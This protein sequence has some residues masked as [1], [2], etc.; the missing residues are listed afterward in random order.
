MVQTVMAT[1]KYCHIH[2]YI[3]HTLQLGTLN[4]C[5]TTVYGCCS[6]PLTIL[7]TST[8]TEQGLCQIGVRQRKCRKVSGCTGVDR[9]VIF[10]DGRSGCFGGRPQMKTP[11]HERGGG[12]D[13][14]RWPGWMSIILRYHN[15]FTGL[16]FIE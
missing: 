8:D 4:N 3:G 16:R 7:L 14:R 11:T 5:V 6:Y 12:S 1:F 15:V 13:G 2:I 9:Y 10:A